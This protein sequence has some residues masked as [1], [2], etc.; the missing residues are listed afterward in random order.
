MHN[1][2][3]LCQ[4]HG[5]KVDEVFV[6]FPVE[7]GLESKQLNG[8][9]QGHRDEVA[10]V[11][12]HVPAQNEHKEHKPSSDEED[13]MGLDHMSGQQ[14]GK[15]VVH[16]L[17]I[18]RVLSVK[19]YSDHDFKSNAKYH[20]DAQKDKQKASEYNRDVAYPVESRDVLEANKTVEQVVCES[21]GKESS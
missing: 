6:G 19:G 8:E 2:C 16:N 4:N 7:M 5:E 15:H 17:V 10:P 9:Q 11:L 3:E 14:M 12:A 21:Q 20:N 1:H 18:P 13:H